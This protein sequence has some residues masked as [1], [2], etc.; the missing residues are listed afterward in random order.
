MFGTQSGDGTSMNASNRG[1]FMRRFSFVK[2]GEDMSV[3]SRCER[4]HGDVW[5]ICEEI[6]IGVV[7][8]YIYIIL[9]GVT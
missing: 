9:N 2:E 3:L 7:S 4:S 5:G 6:M 8:I 1:D